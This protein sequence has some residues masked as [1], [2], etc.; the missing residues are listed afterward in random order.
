M[1]AHSRSTSIMGGSMGAG[2][3]AGAT[4]EKTHFEMQREALIGEIAMVRFFL[5]IFIVSFS[6]RIPTYIHTYLNGM[7]PDCAN[8]LHLFII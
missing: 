5:F 4:R 1:A 8:A 3:G 6:H 7:I 2:G